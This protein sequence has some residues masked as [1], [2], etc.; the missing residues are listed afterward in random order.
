MMHIFN[1]FRFKLLCF[2]KQILLVSFLI[3]NFTTSTSQQK[4]TLLIWDDSYLLTWDD[5]MGKE[6]NHK[7]NPD[8]LSYLELPLLISYDSNKK[9]IYTVVALFNRCKS[10]TSK[11]HYSLLDH[12]QQHF[13]ILEIFARKIRKS[14]DALNK[15]ENTTPKDIFNLYYKYQDSIS[16]HQH[17]YDVQTDYSRNG[18]KQRIWNLTI[19]NKLQDLE[20][21]STKNYYDLNN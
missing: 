18:R 10:F 21:Y 13:N 3:L 4:D 20:K 11:Y 14:V 5:F 2:N 15:V 19:K 16:N 7:N 1:S 9:P 12:E 6:I 17:R 8:A